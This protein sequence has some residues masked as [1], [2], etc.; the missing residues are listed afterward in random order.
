V[1]LPGHC[2]SVKIQFSI[3]TKNTAPEKFSLNL[4]KIIYV[5]NKINFRP[6]VLI[7]LLL[8]AAFSRVIPHPPN[9]TPIAAL[10]L[11]GAAYFSRKWIAIVLPLASLWLSSIVINNTLYAD[12]YK[13]FTF[14]YEG[15]YW[16]FGSIALTTVIGFF[17]LKKININSVLSSS[18]IAAVLF[19]LISNYSCFPGNPS[20]S[21]D[22]RGLMDCYIAGIPFFGGTLGGTLFYSA[23]LFGGF[24]LA[25]YKF[26]A[27]T[28]QHSIS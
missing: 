27:L 26:P 25:K 15:W 8:L 11:F 18:V 5:K 1:I 22:L 14:F 16:I 3:S 4:K 21:Q 2:I 17:T 24:E 23:V 6:I 12:H 13:S 9:F 10:G 28:Q 7:S 19:F 20:Y